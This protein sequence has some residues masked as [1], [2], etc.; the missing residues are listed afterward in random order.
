MARENHEEDIPVFADSS[1][2]RGSSQ[3]SCGIKCH[4]KVG[5]T[6]FPKNYVSKVPV[7]VA[8]SHGE[9][10]PIT[11]HVTN[12]DDKNHIDK[13]RFPRNYINERKI[14]YVEMSRTSDGSAIL[15]GDC[16][17]DWGTIPGQDH[18][19]AMLPS[20][21][22]ENLLIQGDFDDPCRNTLNYAD[23]DF[24]PTRS[25]PQPDLMTSSRTKYACIDLSKTLAVHKTGR[26]LLEERS[27]NVSGKIKG[28]SNSSSLKKASSCFYVS[29]PTEYFDSIEPLMD[30]TEL[31]ACQSK[32]FIQIGDQLPLSPKP[33]RKFS[34]DFADQAKY[35]STLPH[36]K[37]K[38]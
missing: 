23:I 35:P 28:S 17:C 22:S 25:R 14:A 33:L 32:V 7:S 18:I 13:E 36:S 38:F 8:C 16:S 1:L 3:K 4:S 9:I 24:F 21:H 29:T 2:R 15:L 27:I 20:K 19:N 37:K 34:L 10:G 26:E 31:T 11:N 12:G 5:S 6:D 30:K